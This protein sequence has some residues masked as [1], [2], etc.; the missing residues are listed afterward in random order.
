M[1]L[2]L[3]V[4]S[5]AETVVVVIALMVCY[6]LIVTITRFART[7]SDSL[8]LS[9]TEGIEAI[10]SA[11]GAEGE[12]LQSLR[13]A[14]ESEQIEQLISYHR[15]SLAQARIS[16][17]FSLISAS[18]GF[19]VIL[20]GA[21]VAFV[22]NRQASGGLAILSGFIIDTVAA[23][24]FTQSNQA[25]KS[26]TEFFEKLRLDRQFNEALR[27]S[28]SLVNEAKKDDLKAQMALH[29][30]GIRAP[31]KGSSDGQEHESADQL[32]SSSAED[33]TSG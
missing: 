27:L 18:L 26:M 9:I 2:S 15:N 20:V 5:L 31:L 17:W 4:A 10:R 7:E 1:D 19:L 14:L 22:D 13:L 16:F 3:G 6:L 23:L 21:V 33:P 30:S 12:D 28:E 29:F 32:G 8:N 24:F 25:R 11:A